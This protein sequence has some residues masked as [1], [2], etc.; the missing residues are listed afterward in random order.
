VYVVGCNDDHFPQD[1]N[2]ITDEEVC[3]FLVA[4]SRTRKEC[5]LVSC[6]L[7]GA[8]LHAPSRFIDWIHPVV[9]ELKIDAAWF[10]AQ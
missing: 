9:D 5:V 10:A 1:P 2:A 6:K 3:C 8:N 7:F 4:L